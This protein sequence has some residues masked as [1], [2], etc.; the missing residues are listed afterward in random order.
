MKHIVK[1]TSL[2]AVLALAMVGGN[3]LAHEEPFGYLRGAQSEPKGE[4]ELTQWTTGRIGKESGRYLGLDL[5]TELE[6]GVTDRFQVAA[7]LLT[8]YHFLQGAAGGRET[9]ADRDRFGLNGTSL[10]MKYQ[11]FNPY[12]DRVG[13]SLYFE[14]GYRTIKRVGGGRQDELE[15]ETKLIVQKNFLEN[16][17]LAVFN[18]TIEPELE[19]ESGEDW[20]SGLAMDW[21]A[22][23]SWRIAPN[24][25]VGAEA[26]LDTEFADSDLDQ[27]EF[28]TLFAGPTVHYSGEHFYATL[29]VL[30]QV[31]G[32]PDA[33]GTGGLHL[34]DRERLE[35]RFKLGTEF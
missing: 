5:A 20:E 33:R 7:Y 8:D 34:D 21:G 10:E 22:G 25:F 35:I 27:A 32:W 14:P 28:L 11:V 1:R 4:W 18:Y 15:L 17:L 19:K 30:P 12:Q 31:W 3:V 24:W 13:L 26:R 9:F 16:R 2:L 29:T 6:Y 23:L